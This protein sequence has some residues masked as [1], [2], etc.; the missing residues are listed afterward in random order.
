MVTQSEDEIL[1]IS[2]N[3][4]RPNFAM[5]ICSRRMEVEKISVENEHPVSRRTAECKN[6]KRGQTNKT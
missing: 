3:N 2:A 5:A 1:D 6:E 4:S